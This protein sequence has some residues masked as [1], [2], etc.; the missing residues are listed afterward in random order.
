MALFAQHAGR[1]P[2]RT[3]AEKMAARAGLSMGAVFFRTEGFHAP[4]TTERF[5]ARIAAAW[6][7]A[8]VNGE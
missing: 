5:L 3:V 8:A 6:T 1:Q 7:S 4:S 2:A